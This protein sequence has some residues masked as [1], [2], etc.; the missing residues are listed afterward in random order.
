MKILLIGFSVGG[1]MGDGLKVLADYFSR[2]NEVVLITNKKLVIQPHTNLEVHQFTF[3]KERFSDFIN[4]KT[5]RRLSKTIKSIN[6][7][8]AFI[9]NSHP[10]NWIVS[11]LIDK[12]RTIGYLHDPRHHSGTVPFKVR[13]GRLFSVDFRK[14]AKIIVSSHEMKKACIEALRIT[15]PDQVEVVYLGGIE[16]LFFD[17][18]KVDEDIDVMFFGWILSYKGLDTFIE[19]AKKMPEAKFLIAG[20]GS[21]SKATGITT[22]P[23]NCKRIDEYIPDKELATLINRSKIIVLPYR[24]ATGTQTVQI[25]YYYKKPVVATRTGCFPE[26]VRD[27]IDGLI[28]SPNNPEELTVAIKTLVGS[29]AMRR[30]MGENANT[31]LDDIFSND[32]ICKQYMA[33]FEQLIKKP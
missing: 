28:V 5:Y 26:Y 24:D 25:A 15:N 19:T 14:F 31:R 29:E 30:K 9:Y 8:V 22:L 16:N 3:N 6:Y 13:L 21:L 4:L 33:I 11:K 17:L 20:E 27:K 32:R 12:R 1:V 7:D 2:E 10:V 18:P 23:E